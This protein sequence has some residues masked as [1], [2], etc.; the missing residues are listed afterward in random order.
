MKSIK[1][2]LY[3]LL[4]SLMLVLISPTVLP[5]PGQITTVEAAI[6][7]S[8]KSITLIKGQSTTLKITGTKKKA[9]WS[10]NKKAVV[11]VSQTGK[12]VAK[13]KGTA[14][15]TAAIGDQKYNCK[16]TVQTPKMSTS[17]VTLTK[18]DSTKLKL[19]GTDQAITWK[20]SNKNIASV[21]KN[22]KVTAKKKGTVTITAT[23]LKKKYTCKVTVKNPSASSNTSP[24][25]DKPTTTPSTESPNNDISSG[26]STNSVWIPTKGGT[27][28]HKTSTCSGMNGPVTMAV[29]EAIAMGFEPCKKCY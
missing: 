3:S 24:S 22:G 21:N 6:K 29:E 12:I 2:M 5:F 8:K 11:T 14:T 28:Y 23:V 27:K 9:K 7:L 19:N 26:S 16:V 20:S 10:S 17:K 25:I 4:L 1:R 18:G 13:K 15:I